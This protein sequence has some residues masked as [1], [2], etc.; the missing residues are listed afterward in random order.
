MNSHDVVTLFTN[1]PIKETLA[2]IRKGLE[3]DKTLHKCTKLQLDDMELL[4]FVLSTKYFSYDGR[5]YRQIQGAPMGS[6]VS[7]VVS[8]LYMEDHEEKSMGSAPKEMK[9][10]I[11]KRY[12]DDSSRSSCTIRGRFTPHLTAWIRWAV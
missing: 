3:E 7:V 2:I 1:V 4:D 12:V 5:I 9:P 11:W 8:N 10:K 6:L